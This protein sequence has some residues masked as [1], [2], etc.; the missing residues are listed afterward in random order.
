MNN[1]SVRVIRFLELALVPALLAL[2]VL[3]SACSDP[4]QALL[5]NLNEADQERFLKGRSVAAPCWVCH[6][7]AGT[8]KKVGPSLLD[9]YGRKSGLA[10]GYR[11]SPEMISASIV[12]DDRSLAAFLM[13][14]AGFVPGNRMVSPGI[15]DRAALTVFLFYLQRVTRPGAR[16]P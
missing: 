2:G 1:R 14:P 4:D 8:V 6:D 16:T 11:G 12:W 3:F 13:N 10:P 15:R 5:A 7:L 9:V